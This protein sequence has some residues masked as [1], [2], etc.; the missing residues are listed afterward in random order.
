[1]SPSRTFALLALVPAVALGQTAALDSARQAG[2]VQAAATA[3]HTKAADAALADGAGAQAKPPS[4]GSVDLG[5]AAEKLESGDP[6]DAGA[7]AQQATAPERHTVQKGDTLWDITGKYLQN[8]YAWPKVW[9]YN[10]EL[11]NPHHISPGQEVRLGPGKA[12]APV[13]EQQAPVEEAADAGLERPAMEADDVKVVGPY[14]VGF[15]PARGR[16]VRRD[17]FITRK[18]LEQAG[19]I[20][21]SFEEKLLLST[22][23]RAY[24]RFGREVTVQP[25]QRYVVFE[26]ASEVLHPVTH[27][28][29]GFRTTIIGAA[30]VLSVEGG[31]AT[32]RITG[33]Y[34]PIERGALIAPYADRLSGRIE[35]KPNR[36]A[37]KGIIVAGQLDE[38]QIGNNQLV[39]VDK[40]TSDGVEDGNV[41]SV[42]RRGDPIDPRTVKEVDSKPLPEETVGSLVVVDAREHSSTVLVT[43]A[44]LEL[45][46]GDRVEMRVVATASAGAG[47]N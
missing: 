42:L 45:V 12:A 38:S 32:V 31:V 7:A 39:F 37:V 27:Q 24:V 1:M 16:A 22:D 41:F 23:D 40:G 11:P 17:T 4:D 5:R 33:A 13:E 15:V 21:A 28:P 8:P 26:P 29:F 6:A 30:Q 46:V 20:T 9:S 3:R 18:E 2:A 19:R 25:G 36:S 10:P 34:A 43:R 44:N 14:K 47:S 35:E